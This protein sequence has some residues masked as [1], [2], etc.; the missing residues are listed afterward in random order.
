M[1]RKEYNRLRMQRLRASKTY[2]DKERIQKQKHYRMTKARFDDAATQ[3]MT[4]DMEAANENGKA[5]R[6]KYKI[7]KRDEKRKD[8]LMQKAKAMENIELATSNNVELL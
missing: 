8:K 1:I 4:E 5:A 2:S 6:R 7:K 3:A